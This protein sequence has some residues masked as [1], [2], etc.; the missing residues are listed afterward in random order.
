VNPTSVRVAEPPRTNRLALAALPGSVRVARRHVHD[1]LRRW[2]LPHLVE[3]AELVV[4][5]LSTNAIK[6]TGI[7]TDSPSY[8]QLTGGLNAICV[9]LRVT[10]SVAVVEVWDSSPRPPRVEDADPDDEGGRGLFLVERL[11][12]RWGYRLPEAGGKVVWAELKTF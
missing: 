8:G 12:A 3:T 9:S 7:M 10:G 11:T 4:S 5:E 1:L 6:A 2:G